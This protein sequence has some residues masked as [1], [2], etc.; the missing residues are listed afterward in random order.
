M[1]TTFVKSCDQCP[2]NNL[3]DYSELCCNH[4]E[5]TAHVTPKLGNVPPPEACPLRTN[6]Q[7]RIEL[8]PDVEAT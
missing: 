5:A 7:L 4:P 3:A 1:T 2:L 6:G 8:H